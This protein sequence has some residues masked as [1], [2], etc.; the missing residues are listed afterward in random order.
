[1]RLRAG[2]ALATLAGLAL[3]GLLGTLP[4]SAQWIGAP[5][6]STDGASS[7]TVTVT[8]PQAEP[9]AQP[10]PGFSP[11]AAQPAPGFNSGI[12]QPAP[13][14]SSSP[15]VSAPQQQANPNAAECQGQVVKLR[16]DLEK[17]GGALQAASKKKL[18]PSELCPMFRTFANAQQAFYSFLSTN[19]AKC[20]VPDDVLS[21]FKENV[22]SVNSTRNRVCEVAKMQESGAGA[23]P[24]GPPAQGSV[25]AGLGLSTGL[26]TMEAPPGGVFDTLGG[27]ALR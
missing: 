12:G 24:S 6:G 18:P 21:K 26:P 5:G 23:G 11:S 20:G 27:D 17:R 8:P 1:M 7:G 3:V 14:F 16:E 10:A 19:K 2:S 15:G 13:G 9:S 22:T 25:S 4:A